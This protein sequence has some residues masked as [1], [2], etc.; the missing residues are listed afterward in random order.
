MP[1]EEKLKTEILKLARAISEKRSDISDILERIANDQEW[2][3]QHIERRFIE[4]TLPQSAGGR[5][6]QYDTLTTLFS[7]YG[8]DGF[9]DE[10]LTDGI[11][12]RYLD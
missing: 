11:D 8:D 9:I 10:S 1:T 12:H 6:V 4:M 7:L 5:I 2:S 3:D